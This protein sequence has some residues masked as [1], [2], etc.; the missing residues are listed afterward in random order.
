[1][2][3]AHAV[4][5]GAS[6][7]CS[8]G[9]PPMSSWAR[10]IA[11]DVAQSDGSRASSPLAARAALVPTTSAAAYEVGSAPSA[12]QALVVGLAVGCALCG[13]PERQTDD[14]DAHGEDSLR[15]GSVTQHY[16][17]RHPEPGR[18]L[19]KFRSQ[20]AVAIVFDVYLAGVARLTLWPEPF[21]HETVDTVRTVKA[22]L[23]ARGLPV[24]YDR[25]EAPITV[26]LAIPPF[27]VR[28]ILQISP[29][30]D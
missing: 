19:P 25:V 22:W 10:V 16:R 14:G 17:A 6:G 28:P 24:T 15:R 23:T 12:D 18:M 21:G 27:G 7:A 1:M 30:N 29:P 5:T 8:S 9:L 11:A 26:A 4:M 3:G 13:P 2:S 20:R